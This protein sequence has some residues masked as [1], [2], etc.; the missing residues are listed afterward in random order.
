[1]AEFLVS[2]E[3]LAQH[4]DDPKVV[5]LDCNWYL[6]ELNKQGIDDYR[7]GHIPGARFFDLNVISDKA[8]PYINMLPPA[9]QFAAEV[10]KLGIGNDTLVVV[11]DATYVSA[12]IWWMFRVYGHDN[13]RILDGGWKLWK[14]QGRPVET[15]MQPAPAPAKFTPHPRA[16][17]VAGWQ[18]VLNAIKTGSAT[19]VDARTA[20][21]F[22]GQLPSGYPGVPGGHMPGAINIPWGKVIPQ[23]GEFRFI[24]VAA[25]EKLFRDAGV[26]LDRP[27]ITTCGSGVTAAV[28]AL[29]LA[30]LGRDNW[31]L[32]DASW[33]EWGQ[34][35]D[36]P[37]ESV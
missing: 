11:Y 37:K 1:M 19:V 29:A 28:L 36:L 3:W 6:P 35:P 8:S 13:V 4:L 33:H 2:T 20:E 23:S 27:M 26:D 16:N 14:A 7:A 17:A 18:D 25:T 10:G 22:T 9:D 30:R 12:R 32:Y 34:R 21:R 15:G 31:K 5:I 24:D